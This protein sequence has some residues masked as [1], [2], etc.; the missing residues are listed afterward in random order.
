MLC[1]GHVVSDSDNMTRPY[2]TVNVPLQIFQRAKIVA[3]TRGKN[4]TEACSEAFELWIGN[5]KDAAAEAAAAIKTKTKREP[6]A[7]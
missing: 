2:T 3:A 6:Q 5:S 1:L 7:A 4:M